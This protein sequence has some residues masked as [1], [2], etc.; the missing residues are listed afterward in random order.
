MKKKD[1]LWSLLSII[2]VATLSVGLSSCGDDPDPELTVSR[3]KLDF[4][5]NADSKSFSITSNVGWTIVANRDWITVNPSSGSDNGTIY[6]DVEENKDLSDRS[7]RITITASEGGITQTVEVKQTGVKAV[8]TVSPTS[9]S[10]LG[11]K[12]STA[13]LS[14]V[15]TSNWVLTGCPDWLH[16]SATN[17]VG[18]TSIVL[19]TLSAN[20][21]SDEARTATLTFSSNGLT[22][23]VSVEQKSTLPTGLRVN[24]S[25]MTIMS[26]GFACDL[27]FGPNTKGYREAFFTEAA[28]QTMTDKDI[29][30]KLMEQTEYSGSVDY[31][32][33]PGWVDPSTKLVYCVAAYGNES[34]S[35]GSHKYGPITI[36]RITTRSQTIY[37]DLY[38]TSSYNSSR[39]TVSA[40]RQGNYGQRCD[41]FYY[42]A[43][44]DNTA[45]ELYLYANRVT[46]AL[47]AHLFFK[48]N[49]EKDR[50]WNYCNGPQT[51]N[52][53]RSGNRFFC[54]TWGIDRDSKEFSAELSFIYRDLSGSSAR[55]TTRMRSNPSDWNKPFMRPTPAETNRMRNSLRITKVSK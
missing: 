3:D 19:T 39:W 48:P 13:T 42:I 21:M 34:N 30:N 6:V 38:L 40:S 26:D 44:E 15:T 51:M 54:A 9:A 36:E 49:I 16:S 47:L 23:T 43:A 33:L 41:E 7:G 4:T 8:L 18:N 2:M 46:Y 1:F 32:F 12:G 14:V 28:V 5:E 20:D 25:N 35:D 17:G 50:N 52:W 45:D 29:Y 55:E 53:T 37:D 11:E 22:A 27:K 10:L 31:T 24:T